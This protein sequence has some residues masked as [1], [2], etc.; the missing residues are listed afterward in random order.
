MSIIVESPNTNA[1][2][3]VLYLLWNPGPNRYL[4]EELAPSRRISAGLRT[5]VPPLSIYLVF[6][7]IL[8]NIIDKLKQAALYIIFK[9]N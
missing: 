5:E 4:L 2:I 8:L 9:L 7:L 1:N 6:K 3:V